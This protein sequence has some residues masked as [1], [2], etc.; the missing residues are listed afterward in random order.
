MCGEVQRHRKRAN[1]DPA[2]SSPRA[3][4]RLHNGHRPAVCRLDEG[5]VGALRCGALVGC[6]R[7]QQGR[8]RGRNL[9]L[10]SRRRSAVQECVAVATCN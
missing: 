3:P 1:W 8:W 9:R 6:R 5:G 4:E 7:H 2:A 10:P